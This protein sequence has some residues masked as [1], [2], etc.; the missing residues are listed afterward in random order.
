MDV[1]APR[2]Q[3][4][5]AM[6][7]IAASAGVVKGKDRRDVKDT[8]P[9]EGVCQ[10]RR[11][12]RDARGSSTVSVHARDGRARPDCGIIHSGA[13]AVAQSRGGFGCSPVPLRIVLP[14]ILR[15]VTA[16]HCLYFSRHT[17][18]PSRLSGS[19][20]LPTGLAAAF[21]SLAYLL[22]WA[23][24][25]IP[26]QWGG[27]LL[28][29]RECW[30]WKL[31]VSGVF[32]LAAFLYVRYSAL[33]ARMHPW[34][35]VP[36]LVLAILTLFY[37]TVFHPFL[38]RFIGPFIASPSP[39]PRGLPP[40]F[41]LPAMLVEWRPLSFPVIAALLVGVATAFALAGSTRQKREQAVSR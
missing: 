19:R 32:A 1:A 5:T 10:P 41:E 39:F 21:L 12:G 9:G 38:L 22:K 33:A 40:I 34:A 29:F 28:R 20:L 17:M 27:C 8:G 6:R 7:S 31:G 37:P 30:F 23:Y 11:Q 2:V 36:P 18:P 3:V 13:V 35:N 14:L 15:P 16:P 24:A 4:R 26:Y 25:A